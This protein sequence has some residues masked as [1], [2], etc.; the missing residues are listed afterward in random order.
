M[1]RKSATSSLARSVEAEIEYNSF[2]D[3][4]ASLPMEVYQRSSVKALQTLALSIGLVVLGYFVLAIVPWYLVP[5]GWF[6]LGAALTGVFVCGHDC[7]SNAFFR[8]EKLNAVVGTLCLTPLLYPFEAWK[9]QYYVEKKWSK[10]ELNPGA[11]WKSLVYWMQRIRD[12]WGIWRVKQMGR[13]MATVPGITSK[14]PELRLCLSMLYVYAFVGILFPLL[15][16]TVGFWGLV[17]YYLAPWLCLHFWKYSFRQ[18]TFALK[19]AARSVS[20]S[21]A[22]RNT[23]QPVKI[24][25]V[26]CRFPAWLEFLFHSFNLQVSDYLVPADSKDP[27]LQHKSRVIPSYN[28][29]LAA[30][31]LSKTKQEAIRQYHFH[32]SCLF[33]ITPGVVTTSDLHASPKN[34]QQATNSDV[35]TPLFQRINWLHLFI[36]TITPSLALYGLVNWEFSAKTLLWS[37][38]YYYCTGLGITGGYHRLWAH[39]AFKASYSVRV[40]LMLF[41]SGS[42]QGSIRWWCRDHRVHHRYTDTDKDPYNAKRGF[43]YSHIGWMLLKKPRSSWVAAD[44]SDLNADPMIR[45]QHKFYLPIALF[46]GA[47][48]PALVAGWG[49][50]DYWG[51]FFVAGF[52]RLVFVHHSTFCINSVAHAWGKHTYADE[53][54]PRDS[55]VTALVTLGEGYHN[56]HHEFP[57][58]YRNGIRFYHYDP[59]KWIIRGLS[60]LGLAWDLKKFPENEIQKGKWQMKWKRLLEEKARIAWPGP[61][62]DLPAIPLEEYH[63][64]CSD[65]HEWILIDGLVHDVTGFL[66][67][68]PG[69]EKLLRAYIGKDATH[70]FHGGVHQHSNAGRNLLSTKRIARISSIAQ[71]S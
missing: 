1:A 52:A 40:V 51:G 49:W 4:L 35:K 39:R 11:I 41:G 38:V 29:R 7:G 42:V 55:V 36:L 71:S 69:G 18:S 67:S 32:L 47:I 12:Y 31:A 53:H 24:E 59:T 27:T 63:T 60:Y 16:W 9:F 37:V 56:F 68:H 64:A 62:E 5:L 30:K 46:M 6:F 61:V 70:A 20:N 57:Y 22:Q 58:D 26:Q 25:L 44:I 43:F 23:P 10:L 15:V 8:S 54:T 2:S 66:E 3:V 17:K 33:G 21:P 45:F 19:K 65:G 48:F 50:G 13:E 14:H 28:L 34:K